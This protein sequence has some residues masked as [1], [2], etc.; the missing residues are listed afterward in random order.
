MPLLIQSIGALICPVR[1]GMN[2]RTI[3]CPDCWSHL[4]RVHGDTH[5]LVSGKMNRQIKKNIMENRQ[6]YFCLSFFDQKVLSAKTFREKS[7]VSHTEDTYK[8][9]EDG[10]GIRY[11]FFDCNLS[12]V[13]FVNNSRLKSRAW[14]SYVFMTVSGFVAEGPAR[15]VID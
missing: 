5:D 7:L 2:R 11:A 10:E 14:N 15:A 8:I 4:P 9:Q 3:A 13:Y 6:I 12:H 1:T